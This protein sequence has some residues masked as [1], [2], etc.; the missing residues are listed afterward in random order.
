[1]HRTRRIDPMKLRRILTPFHVRSDERG[2]A[3][4]LAI[5]VLTIMSVMVTAGFYAVRQE[6]RMGS[7]SERVTRAK[8]QAQDAATGVL[9][10]WRGDVYGA[11]PIGGST[12]VADSTAA[13]TTVV[14]VGRKGASLFF[15]SAE[16]RVGLD[17]AG[18]AASTRRV[19]MI[20]RLKLTQFFSHSALV[21]SGNVALSG[22]A[23]IEG[24]DQI[25]LAWGPVCGA[26]GATRPGITNL[27]SATVSIA[28]AA[29]VTGVPPVDP[30][31]PVAGNATTVFSELTWAQLVALA[32]KTLPGGNVGSIAPVSASG[33]C[34]TAAPFNWGNPS[35]PAAPC[36]SY[37]PIVHVAG[38]ARMTGGGLGQGI[39]LVDGNL[40]I[41]SPFGF[42]GIVVV[43]GRIDTQANVGQ[44][45]GH[46][47]A[48]DVTLTSV[49][50][51]VPSLISLSS[52]AIH[53][54][55]VNHPMLTRAVPIGARSWVDLTALDG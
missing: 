17:G 49:S 50:P 18:G 35:H 6:S 10:D 11:L 40:E 9:A 2:V 29:V 21:T 3:F 48:E 36:G 14:R 28:G 34:D 55:V 16:A 25:P 52:C 37:F 15:L 46:V 26:L 51:T 41:V 43:R 42:F 39:L 12:I 53:R 8:Y 27:A 13:G 22:T 24:T 19:G 7:A 54:A 32:D 44:F 23:R 47:R 31:D 33:T 30:N 5:V 20:A 38:D 1:M 45:Y 4:L